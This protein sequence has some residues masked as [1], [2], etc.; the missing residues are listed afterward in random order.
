MQLGWMSIACWIIVYSPQI[1]ENYS[2]QSGEGLSVPFVVTWLLGDLSNLVGAMMAGLLPTT[3]LLAIYYSVCDVTLL[4]QVYY[5]RWKH[6]H[7]RRRSSAGPESAPLLPSET[8]AAYPREAPTWQK[9]LSQRSILYTAGFLFV[10][11]AGLLASTI[12]Q[13]G[14]DTPPRDEEEVLEW[15]SQTL[16]W[17]SAV[18]Y[19]GSRIP[20]I[21]KNAKTKCAGLSLAL[22]VFAIGGNLTFTLSILV[23]S[24]SKN[25]LLANAGWLAG[26]GLTIFLDFVVLSQFF[27]YRWEADELPS[28]EEL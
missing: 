15:K 18:M 25:H 10:I 6:R 8:E 4:V 3:I 7:R 19:L 17:I 11:S 26:S 1:Y 20:Q 12:T 23:A 21:I 28:D 5:Y 9:F 16:G 2:L 14:E 13:S 24:T 27:Y 22:F